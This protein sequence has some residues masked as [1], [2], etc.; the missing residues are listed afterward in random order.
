MCGA[1]GKLQEKSEKYVGK[2]F[3]FEATDCCC[4]GSQ[5]VRIEWY[6]GELV[7]IYQRLA[8]SKIDSHR[9]KSAEMSKKMSNAPWASVSRQ[10]YRKEKKN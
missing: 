10:L 9:G 1:I 3:L 5:K 4:A 2:K 7:K 8:N 6:D